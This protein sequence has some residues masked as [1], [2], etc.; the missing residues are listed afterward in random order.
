MIELE[1][2]SHYE[3]LAHTS[4]EDYEKVAVALKAAPLYHQWRTYQ[5]KGAHIVVNSYNTGTGK[6]KAAL[7][8]LLDLGEAYKQDRYTNANVLFIA[9]TNELLRQHEQDIEH[10]IEDNHLS[11][12]VLRLDAATI[13]ALGQ[14]HLGE[15]FTR[16]GDRLHQMLQDPR[17]VLLDKNGH[18]VEGHHPYVLVINPDIFYYALYDLGNPHDQRVLF[19]SF[20]NT[21]QYIVIDE[22]HYYNA[23]QLANF[24]FFLTLSR[25]WEYFSRGRKICLLTA[26]PAQQVKTYLEHLGLDIEYIVPGSEPPGLATT[27]AFAPV[28][29]HLWSAEALEDGLVSLAASEKRRV[30]DWLQ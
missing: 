17:S 5:A 16:Q 9:P 4:A 27:L 23:K 7:L 20:L 13:K 18:H 19:R 10:F 11:H 6:T 15:K 25:E 3:A 30:E 14:Q 21:F 12:L 29:L 2:A 26:T 8:R 22:F 24:L 28:R 1:L